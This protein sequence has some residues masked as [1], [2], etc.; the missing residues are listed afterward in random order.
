MTI[1]R[2][3]HCAIETADLDGTVAFFTDMLGLRLGPRPDVPVAGAWLYAGDQPVVHLVDRGADKTGPTGAFDHIAFRASGFA[4]TK[5]RLTQAGHAVTERAL[6]DMDLK[7][8]LL[9][10][11]NGVLVE[12]NFVGE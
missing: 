6:P 2:L 8:L 7:Q 1:E 5:A 3:D 10:D 11:P 12:L 4:E 9:R